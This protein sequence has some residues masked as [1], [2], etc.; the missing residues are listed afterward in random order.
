MLLQISYPSLGFQIRGEH[1]ETPATTVWELWDVWKEDPSMASRNHIVTTP[2]SDARALF[3]QASH[4]IS[5]PGR[6]AIIR[7]WGGP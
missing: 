7:A 2:E 3:E 4:A 6:T 5:L 1:G